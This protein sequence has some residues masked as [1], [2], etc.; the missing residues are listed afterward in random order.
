MAEEDVA[1]EVAET[2]RRRAQ[3]DLAIPGTLPVLPLKETVVFPEAVAPL[4]IGEARSVR[5]IDEVMNRPDRMV[6][7][8]T[9][10]DPELPEP[11]PDQIHDIGTVAVVQRMVRV[12]DGT[13]RI[14]AQG[15][16]RIRVGPYTQTDPFLEA[17]RRGGPSTTPSAPPRSR[18]WRATSRASSAA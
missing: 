14:L 4:A 10:R 16:R 9:S 17:D 2:P 1:L 7:L 18:R 6:A 12:P 8:V 13:V 5:L 15:L 3:P 11:G